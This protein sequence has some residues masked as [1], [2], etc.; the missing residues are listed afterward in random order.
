[1]K[2]KYGDG[3]TKYGPGV[4]VLLTGAEVAIAIDAFLV[5]HG[6]HISGPRTVTVNNELCDGG[7]DIQW[8]K[9]GEFCPDCGWEVNHDASCKYYR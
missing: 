5:A 6:V 7:A 1:M 9:D 2:I 8:P 4:E 3:T